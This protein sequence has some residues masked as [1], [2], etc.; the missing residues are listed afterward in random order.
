MK[1]RVLFLITFTLVFFSY[2]V[3]PGISAITDQGK[4][5]TLDTKDNDIRDVLAGLA[6]ANG[7]NLLMSNSVQ[8]RINISLSNVPFVKAIEMIA[9]SNGYVVET[10]DNTIVVAKS[11]DIKGLL[12][13]TSKVIELQ[14]ASAND[15]KQALSGTA[16]EGI[17][18]VADQRTNSI[19]VT[20]LERNVK[21]IEEIVKLLDVP[22]PVKS[23]AVAS[24]KIFMLKYA[25]VAAIQ[26]TISDLCSP[27]GKVVIEERTNSLIVTD[28]PA[29][30][31]KISE[32]VSQLDIQTDEEKQKAAQ[33]TQSPPP[34]LLTQV[35]NLNHVEGSAIKP[36][37]QTILTTNGKIESFMKRR[38]IVIVEAMSGGGSGGSGGNGGGSG[39]SSKGMDNFYKEKWSDTL[40]VT[41]IPEVIEKVTALIAEL[42]VKSPQVRIEA[43]MVEVELTGKDQLGISWGATHKSSG[44]TIDG[45]F[46]AIIDNGLDVSISTMSIDSFKDILLRLQALQTKGQAKLVSN[47]S[48]IAIDNELAQMIVAD[49]IPLVTTYESQFSSSTKVEFINIGVMLNVIPHITDDGYILVDVLPIVDSIKQW[50]TGASP[51]PIISSRVAHCRV[52]VKDGETFVIGGL[53]KDENIQS[54]EHVP[55]LGKLPL[56]GRLFGTTTDNKTKTDL[57]VFIT[58]KLVKDDEK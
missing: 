52:R 46:P 38:D 33:A 4:P 7:T 45:L 14:Y 36:I 30:F 3:M 40:I 48:V 34:V 5:V 19:L 31:D 54:S 8:G 10:F 9:K 50:T 51:Q 41:D 27:T 25:R 23:Q 37:I 18:M 47:P 57:M 13:K 29:V 56:I 32:F 55:F 26:K 12:P 15:L 6:K 28:Q 22:I 20:G 58:T 35:F 11:E 53:V 1:K 24:T 16:L 42:D 21:R 44:S 43:K 17:E 2:F 39:G 49:K